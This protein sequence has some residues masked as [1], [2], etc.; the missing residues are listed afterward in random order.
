MHGRRPLPGP[1]RRSAQPRD[2]LPLV[3][4]ASHPEL[5]SR[6]WYER[7]DRGN[8]GI[9]RSPV[10]ASILPDI[11]SWREA[12]IRVPR[13]RVS[14]VPWCFGN[15]SPRRHGAPSLRHQTRTRRRGSAGGGKAALLIW[16]DAVRDRSPDLIPQ[17]S[18]TATSLPSPPRDLGG[19]VKM[20]VLPAKW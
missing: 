9:I 7:G 14:E 5:I 16:V 15:G 17:Q 6:R 2:K 11:K 18:N 13:R 8:V 3:A 20:A 4:Q 10:R 1:R 12:V 19:P